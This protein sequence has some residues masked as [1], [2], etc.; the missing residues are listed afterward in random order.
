MLNSAAG[1]T[2]PSAIAP[3]IRTIR[4][5]GRARVRA[6]AAARRSSAGRSGPASPAG[7]RR[8][9]SA[10][11]ST[12][13]SATGA[14]LRRRQ[15]GAVHPGLAVDVRGDEALAHERPVGAGG[16]RDVAAADEL[17]HAQRVRR[18][19]LQRLV[20]GDCRDADEL[21]SGLASASRIAIA[22]SWPGSQSR[23]IGVVIGAMESSPTS[24]VG[25]I[26]SGI[27]CPFQPELRR[28]RARPPCARA[29]ALACGPLPP[30][31]RD[32]RPR[33]LVHASPSP[34]RPPV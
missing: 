27:L 14:P 23:R 3:P 25:Q 28:G 18:R 31:S 4:S 10:R 30:S 12:A 33:P 1:V 7:R 21:D 17:E 2:L 19:L 13:C 29:R 15:V 8:S 32:P 22:S 11:N 6:R 9:R 5:L 26:R 24:A 16:H 34:R 20:A